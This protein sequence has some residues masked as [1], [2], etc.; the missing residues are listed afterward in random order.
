VQAA[1]LVHRMASGTHKR[2]EQPAYDDGAGRSRTRTVEL[3]VYPRS[4]GRVL[5]HIGQDLEQTTEL[6]VQRKLSAVG[7]IV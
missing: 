5:R 6:L 2:W 3:H 1:K 7:T 4:R